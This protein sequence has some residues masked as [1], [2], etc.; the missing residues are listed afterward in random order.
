MSNHLGAGTSSRTC[1]VYCGARIDE[2]PYIA[3]AEHRAL[4][5]LDPSYQQRVD[6]SV[7]DAPFGRVYAPRMLEAAEYGEAVSA[8]RERAS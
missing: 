8:T 7:D 5:E 6:G 1:C 4:L 3:C 2:P